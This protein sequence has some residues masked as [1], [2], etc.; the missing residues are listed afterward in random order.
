MKKLLSI[1]L[2]LNMFCMPVLAEYDFSDEAQ[3]EFDRQN[4]VQTQQ[5]DF[6]KKKTKNEIKTD[7]ISQ[8]EEQSANNEVRRM[9]YQLPLYNPS[10]QNKLLYGSVI[11]VPAGTTFDVTFDSGISSGSLDKSDRL[12]VRLTK[13]LVYNGQVVA[14]AGSLIYGSATGAKNAGYAYGNAEIELDF[15]EL[16][17][18]DGTILQIS[19][20]KV[21]MKTK[22]ER[23]SKMTRD[24]VVGAL[25]SMLVGAAFTALGGGY[26]WGRNMAIYGGLGALGGG[27]YGVT[28]HGKEVDIKDGATIQLKLTQP[29]KVQQAQ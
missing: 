3:A 13:D 6:S 2:C 21:Y 29:L 26:N 23:A 18:S 9:N 10:G 14:P 25:G 15:N 24:V 5:N 4:G 17:T 22:S 19:T 16:M 28:Q 27:I 20:E 8:P 12:T 1:I 11:T 7:K